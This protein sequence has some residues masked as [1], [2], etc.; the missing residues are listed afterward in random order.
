M[1]LKESQLR[2]LIAFWINAVGME[3]GISKVCRDNRRRNAMWVLPD[4]EFQYLLGYNMGYEWKTE[5]MWLFVA[6]LFHEFGHI[7]AGSILYTNSTE[8]ERA[9]EE[10]KAERL[11][12]H[13]LSK[14]SPKMKAEYVNYMRGRRKIFEKTIPYCYIMA[15]ERV[16]KKF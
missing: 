16:Y 7:L 1:I 14:Y 11:A 4:N 9:D 13:L 10:E 15:F 3:N 6:T 8:K 5:N 12:L 2:E